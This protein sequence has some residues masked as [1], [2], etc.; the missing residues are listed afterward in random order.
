MLTAGGETAAGILKGWDEY[1]FVTYLLKW[2]VNWLELSVIEYC[3]MVNMK[4]RKPP[5]RGPPIFMSRCSEQR[6]KMRES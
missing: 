3:W 5:R 6:L 2:S 1:R 4:N